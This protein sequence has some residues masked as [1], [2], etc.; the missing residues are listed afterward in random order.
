MQCSCGET[1]GGDGRILRHES[2]LAWQT[3][4]EQ[5]ACFRQGGR[6][7]G[8][9]PRLS[10]DLHMSLDH[11]CH[12]VSTWVYMS[13]M[14]THIHTCMFAHAHTHIARQINRS[15]TEPGE[16]AYCL[17]DVGRKLLRSESLIFKKKSKICKINKSYFQLQFPLLSCCGS[18]PLQTV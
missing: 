14:H 15:L 11:V 9:H 13:H 10:L 1:G 18:G 3:C 16:F 2:L 12:S 5:G 17:F 6:E 7:A 4:E 8:K